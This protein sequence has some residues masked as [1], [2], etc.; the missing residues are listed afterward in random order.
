M[1]YV[2]AFDIGTTQAKGVLL[3]QDGKLH[4]THG[5][6]L[7]TDQTNGY[8]EQDPQSWYD[9]VIQIVQ[10]WRAQSIN[11]D[12][13]A[14]I[15]LSGQMQDC[16]LI[17]D[18]GQPVRPAILY[19]DGRAQTQ[20]EQIKSALTA[21]TIRERTGNHL[22]GTLP[23][24]KLSWLAE[25]EPVSLKN[26]ASVLI[27]AKDYL[28]RQLTG[29]CATDPTT[30]AT[31]GMMNIQEWRWETDFLTQLQLPVDKLPTIVP[32]DQIVGEVTTEAAVQTG[33]APGTPVLCGLGDAGATTLGSGALQSGDVYAYVGTSGWM[34][35]VADQVKPVAD[36]IFHLAYLKPGQA[37]VAPPITN[38]GLVHQ[39]ASQ[40]FAGADDK[41]S[42]YE[43]LE[44]QMQS[45]DRSQ[46]D[47]LFL[48]YLN[49]ERFPVQ[50]PDATGVYVGIRPTTSR[51]EMSV[52]ALEG[53]AMAMRQSLAQLAPTGHIRRITLIGGGSKSAV[54]CQVFADVLGVEVAVP[55]DSTSIPSLGAA[56]LGAVQLGW[57]ETLADFFA[58]HNQQITNYAPNEAVKAQMERKYVRYQQLYPAVVGLFGE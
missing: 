55:H 50:N 14:L 40:V 57:C 28:I 16:I 8:V 9:A 23:L 58:Q 48:P 49:G 10:Y 42:A 39:W 44:V 38:A 6:D 4:H 19:S 15:S 54:W 26:T 51:A 37:I 41:E 5:V 12:A 13:I 20:A 34:A 3:G 25:H 22:D 53:V 52:T 24:P 2:A 27:S 36:G 32:A 18:A 47:L 21:E 17:D 33:L 11:T 1:S 7:M 31:T 35:M 46:S 29:I 45:V 30:A 56:S 43:Q